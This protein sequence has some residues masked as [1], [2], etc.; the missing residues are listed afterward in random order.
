MSAFKRDQIATPHELG[1][2]I[3]KG[4]WEACVTKKMDR[5][6][7]PCGT[8]DTREEAELAS[9]NKFVELAAD[10]EIDEDI[11]EAFIISPIGETMCFISKR[12]LNNPF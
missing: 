12:D 3:L 8:F 4:K 10:D 7:L 2:A 1:I 11:D 5:L 9:A 6:V